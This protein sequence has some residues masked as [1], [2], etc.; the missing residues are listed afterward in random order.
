MLH[1]VH[2]AV[3]LVCQIVERYTDGAV[4]QLDDGQLCP[5]V[6]GN[7]LQRTDVVLENLVALGKKR[8]GNAKKQKNNDG[9]LTGN[10]RYMLQTIL[11]S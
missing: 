1:L 11:H 8:L 4:M 7:N 3:V 6:V 10:T 2:I 9:N 5:L